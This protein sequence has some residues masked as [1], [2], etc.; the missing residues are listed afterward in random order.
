MTTDERTAKATRLC[1]RLNQ[2][3]AAVAQ[4]GL[5]R[6]E[7]TGEIV[8]PVSTGFMVKLTAWEA[9]GD[10]SLIPLLR[11]LYDDVVAEWTEA[12]SQYIEVGR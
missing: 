3:V 9:T 4:L 12:A 6:W 8:G 7:Q 10:R 1:E 2:D 5:G 11:D